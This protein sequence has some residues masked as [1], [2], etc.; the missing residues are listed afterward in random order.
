MSTRQH[1][2]VVVGAGITGLAAAHEACLAGLSVAVVEATMFGGLVVNVNELDGEPGGSGAELSMRMAR[3]AMRGGAVHLSANVESVTGGAD[4]FEVATDV[5]PLRA[6]AVLAAS[7]ARLRRLGV[8]GETEL[9]DLGVSS[10]ADC[11]GP[12]YRGKTV[13]VVG[14][15]DSAIQEALV[16]AGYC[17]QVVVVHRGERFSARA[18]LVEALGRC[19]NV[20]VRWRSTVA[21]IVGTDGVTGV[22]VAG[23]DGVVAD[24]PCEGVFAYVGLEP[25]AQW[26]PPDA[27]R[28]A[29]GALVTDA[30]FETAVPGLFAAGAVRSGYRGMLADAIAEGQGAARSVIARLAP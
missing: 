16:L 17:G 19:T 26:A 2:L 6:R 8:P 18:R 20:A 27:P 12:L 21:E 5:E 4:G 11:D 24:L 10:C 3:D 14:G 29:A 1:D 9:R 15:G 30:A 25:V 22:R 23:P 13:V 28:D 7:G